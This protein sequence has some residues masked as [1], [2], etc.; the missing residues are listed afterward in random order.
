MFRR[1]TQSEEGSNL[2]S[3]GIL[4]E[5][6]DERNRNRASLTDNNI[7]LFTPLGKNT[8]LLLFL[9]FLQ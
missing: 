4:A 3:T 7:R 8:V 5:K 9:I 6:A 2:S 1:R